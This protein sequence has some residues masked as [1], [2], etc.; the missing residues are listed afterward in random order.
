MPSAGFTR[1]VRALVSSKLSAGSVILEERQLGRLSR[2]LFLARPWGLC[3]GFVHRFERM[4][5]LAGASEPPIPTVEDMRGCVPVAKL[6]EAQT[7]AVNDD[8]GDVQ[9]RKL[10]VTHVDALRVHVYGRDM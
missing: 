2:A 3:F 1:I 6:F 7:V 8:S 4:H 10:Q 5:F 9:E